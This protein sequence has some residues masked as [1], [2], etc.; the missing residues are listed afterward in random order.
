MAQIAYKW[1]LLTSCTKN[2]RK[3]KK[4]LWKSRSLPSLRPAHDRRISKRRV[5]WDGQDRPY[6]ARGF[7]S[8]LEVLLPFWEDG[9]VLS[10]TDGL[11][12]A[13]RSTSHLIISP[14]KNAKTPPPPIKSSWTDRGGCEPNFATSHRSPRQFFITANKCDW[15]DN[16]HVVFGQALLGMEELCTLDLVWF[17]YL[18]GVSFVWT[19]QQ[20]Q[21]QQQGLKW[22][23]F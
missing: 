14:P 1:G 6:C 13:I 8:H 23:E 2:H 9:D 16:K 18:A 15:L 11:R 19:L 21:Q 17:L 12:Q 5:V 3:R 10:W 22:F 7:K 20:Q 4:S